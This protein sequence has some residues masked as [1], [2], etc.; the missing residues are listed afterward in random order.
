M[1]VS[2]P[3]LLATLVYVMAGLVLVQAIGLAVG[4]L[5]LSRGVRQAEIGIERLL[6]RS[7]GLV[8][9]TGRLLALIAAR[10]GGFQ[11]ALQQLETAVNSTAAALNV[12]DQGLADLFRSSRE[13]LRQASRQLEFVLVR[14]DKVSLQWARSARRLAT[15]FRALR[16]GAGAALAALG[17]GSRR[18]FVSD[19]DWFI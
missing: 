7:R 6:V 3:Q 9:E 14:A 10:K 15:Q 12:L 1:Q 13:L 2:D 18:R 8:Q 5:K 11:L 19:E 16:K 4:M 17:A